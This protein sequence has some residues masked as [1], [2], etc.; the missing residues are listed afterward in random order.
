MVGVKNGLVVT[1]LTKVMLYGFF[2]RS[3]ASASRTAPGPRPAPNAAAAAPPS[4]SYFRRNTE[5]L[6]PAQ[7]VTGALGRGHALKDSLLH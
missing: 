2:G 6:A 4:P 1:W 3:A 7:F 5:R